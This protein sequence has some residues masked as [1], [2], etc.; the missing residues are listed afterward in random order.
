LFLA[1][2]FC[3]WIIIERILPLEMALRKWNAENREKT[4]KKLV[5]N[6]RAFSSPNL[7]RAFARV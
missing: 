5:Y 1:F 4:K 2:L 3:V 6:V 7:A